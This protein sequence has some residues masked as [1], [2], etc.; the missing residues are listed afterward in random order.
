M[1]YADV[2][3][4]PLLSD[5]SGKTPEFFENYD[6]LR[7]VPSG[8][9][10]SSI[11]KKDVFI[12][13]AGLGMF[14]LILYLVVAAAASFEPAT[15]ATSYSDIVDTDRGLVRGVRYNYKANGSIYEIEGFRG[16][17]FAQPPVG[18]LRWAAPERIKSPWDGV[19]D[20]TQLA[21]ACVQ[22]D[23]SGSEDC[24]YLN[25]YRN[26]KAS[27]PSDGPFPVLFY[28]YGGGLMSGQA[29]NNFDSLITSND[30]EGLVVVEIGYRLNVFGFL[31]IS[32][33]SEETGTSGNYGIMDQL[34][35]LSWVQRNIAKFGGDPARVTLA[36]QSSGGTSIMALLSSPSAK[37]LFAGA[38]SMSGSPNISTPLSLAEAQNSHFVS[39]GKGSCVGAGDSASIMKC[40]RDLPAS[41]LIAVI[42]EAWNM[43]GIW[44]LPKSPSGQ[45]Y[46]GLVIVDGTLIPHDF[47]TALSMGTV[48]VPL[49]Y[50]NM[51]CES[52]EG[53]EMDVSA[54]SMESWAALLN[55]TF[56][57]WAEPNVGTTIFDLY[58]S[59]AEQNP[60]KA[61]DEI[62]SD[63]GLFCGQ[64]AVA[65]QALSPSSESGGYQSSIYIY[66]DQWGLSQSYTSPWTGTTVNYPFHDVFFFMV[67]GQ[68]DLVGDMGTYEPSKEDL[69]AQKLLQSILRFFMANQSLEGSNLGW[70][71][72]NKDPNWASSDNSLPYG[73][74]SVF[75]IDPVDT[76]T[77]L[78]HK[79]D[80]CSYY[81][82]I[83]LDQPQF[84]WAN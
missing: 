51:Q 9:A 76:R 11:N 27:N 66:E 73:N 68:W 41:D 45:H 17:P 78:N 4:N 69:R 46:E 8:E 3:E 47:P 42:P 65:R 16:I 28:I 80:V 48:D 15:G 38:I 32:E 72:V 26:S 82:S 63:Y 12:S 34:L 30:N 43:P 67:T 5:T 35:A 33:L 25:V 44:N 62:V 24:L 49:I 56:E 81:H 1:S 13:S 83:G 61:F 70:D 18:E 10:C 55:N 14:A 60:Q 77:V 75:V 53:P 19:L 20:A 50:G 74:Y 40:L 52:D 79:L 22:P 84:W 29:N 71:P 23:G 7:S 21:P 59:A 6:S 39:A 37:G 64:L 2:V 36:G 57:G 54:Y 31:A 58:A